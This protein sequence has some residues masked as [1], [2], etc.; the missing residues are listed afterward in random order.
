M[1]PA[2]IWIQQKL[3][4][5]FRPHPPHL[6]SHPQCDEADQE[7]RLRRRGTRRVVFFL[8]FFNRYGEFRRGE[9]EMGV[10]R[11]GPARDYRMMGNIYVAVF[12]TRVSVGGIGAAR[13]SSHAGL[14]AGK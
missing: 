12:C 11:V 6:G 1:L 7:R 8:F 14:L 13:S 4:G 2:T 9:K 5:H 10:M 3:V